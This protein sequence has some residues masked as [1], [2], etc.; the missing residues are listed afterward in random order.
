MILL[1]NKKESNYRNKKCGSKVCA[2]NY[3]PNY[4]RSF[5]AK[6]CDGFAMLV[7]VL[8]M[9]MSLLLLI[10]RYAEFQKQIADSVR[11]IIENE[12]GLQSAFVCTSRVSFILSRYPLLNDELLAGIKSLS[13]DGSVDGGVDNNENNNGSNGE[14]NKGNCGVV[15]F[16][17][18]KD[19]T[20]NYRSLINGGNLRIYVEWKLDEYRFYI[21]KL[22]LIQ[23][24]GNSLEFL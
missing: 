12:S 11:E 19:N 16:D 3:T 15:D 21:S 4:C 18:C 22:R 13:V 24:F 2:K 17:K 14:N 5:S 1:N 6:N 8:I 10:I 20:C 9:A 23:N 7:F